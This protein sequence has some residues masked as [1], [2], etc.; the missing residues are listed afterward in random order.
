MKI[1]LVVLAFSWL[2]V[3]GSLAHKPSKNNKKRSKVDRYLNRM[4]DQTFAGVYRQGRVNRNLVKGEAMNQFLQVVIAINSYIMSTAIWVRIVIQALCTALRS[5]GRKLP[6]IAKLK[7]SVHSS[8]GLTTGEMLDIC[9][10]NVSQRY[11]D[12]RAK[13][14]H[15]EDWF[16]VSHDP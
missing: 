15:S 14:L 12:V 6:L 11:S 16:T 10:H 3:V 7:N 8:F 13:T 1:V 4:T 5:R 9:Q 2:C